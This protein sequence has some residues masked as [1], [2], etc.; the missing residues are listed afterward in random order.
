MLAC[1]HGSPA[2]DQGNSF[3]LT[4]DQRGLA[5]SYDDP[6]VLNAPGGDGSD[7]GAFELQPASPALLQNVST[8]ARVGMDDDVLVVLAAGSLLAK[9]APPAASP[10]FSSFVT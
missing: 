8:R 9:I 3:G 10:P 4:T 7:I 2:I 6:A 5:R 1:L